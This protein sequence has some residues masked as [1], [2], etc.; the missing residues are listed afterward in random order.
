MIEVISRAAENPEEAV[1]A[2]LERTVV[3]QKAEMPLADEA[4]AVACPLE[5]RGKGGVAWRQADGFWRAGVNGLFEADLK[6]HLIAS[7]DQRGAGRR[8]ICG[9]RVALGESQSL[10]RQAI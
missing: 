1:V 8:A 9:V 10:E 7:G 4:G 2:A 6:T 5:Q 3:R